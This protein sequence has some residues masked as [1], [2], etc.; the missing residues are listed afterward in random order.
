[1]RNVENS[2]ATKESI[3]CYG[4]TCGH[5]A[6]GEELGRRT[7]LDATYGDEKSH[8][9]TVEV[10]DGKPETWGDVLVDTDRRASKG[11]RGE[12][13]VSGDEENVSC[14]AEIPR[15]SASRV[16]PLNIFPDSS[17]RDSSIY[18]GTPG[19]KR[20]FR[21]VDRRESK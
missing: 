12:T 2:D 13:M 7:S 10:A 11:R 8:R 1:M 21:I 17:H 3:D 14:A 6:N 20:D 19:W 9:E 18:R 4:C 5:L 15:L 16:V